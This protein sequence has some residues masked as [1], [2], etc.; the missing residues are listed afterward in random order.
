MR[1][2][3]LIVFGVCCSLLT[4]A[5]GGGSDKPAASPSTGAA[6][7]GATNTPGPTPTAV[8][9]FPTPKPAKDSDIVVT[10]VRAKE[11]Y[12]PTFAE[13]RGLPQTDG[14]S[15]GKR[16][17]ALDLLA[18]RVG[19][20]PE[21]VVTIEGRNQELTRIT[22]YRGKVRDLGAKAIFVVDAE[23]HVSFVADSLPKE[24]WIYAI[25]G[26]SFQ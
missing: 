3:R 24:Q 11:S 6:A 4:V 23:G 2:K 20:G 14:G 7:V 10:V 22:F 1:V 12:S 17:V 25:T 13:F 5:C 18:Q 26:V 8:S 9:Q 21:S 19:A 16:G 15:T